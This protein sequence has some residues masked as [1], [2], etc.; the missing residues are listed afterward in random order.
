MQ[1]EADEVRAENQ[2]LSTKVTE[3]QSS[4]DNLTKRIAG[5]ELDSNVRGTSLR[6]MTTNYDQLIKHTWNY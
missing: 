3:L 2:K 5:L 1:A 6:T 4:F